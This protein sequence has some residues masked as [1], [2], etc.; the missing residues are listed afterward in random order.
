[1]P[2][3]PATADAIAAAADVLRA[4]GLVALPTETVYGLGADATNARA[5]AADLRGQGA[6]EVQSADRAC[7]GD[8]AAP[9]RIAVC[10]PECARRLAAAFWPGPLTLVL[11]KRR[12]VRIADLATAG[13]DTVAIRVPSASGGAGAACVPPACRSPRRRPTARAMSARR[14]PRTS[15]RIS[16]TRSP[17][18]STAGRARSESNRPWS[19]CSGPAPALLRAGGVTAEA[20]EARARCAARRARPTTT[21]RPVVARPAREPLCAA[22]RGPPRRNRRREPGEALLAFGPRRPSMTA[23]PS[24]SARPATLIEA[25]ANLF[26]ALRRL[27]ATGAATI[28]VMPIPDDRPRRGDQRP[29][30]ARGGTLT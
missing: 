15:R 7:R 27:D 23:R 9:R 12:T 2:I 16:A 1:M 17:S 30:A 3:R 20:I 13:L 10:E 14:R 25:A 5:V 19:T 18:F 11:R 8:R 22:R 6:A 29:P 4:G 21:G 28:A 24:T 26:A